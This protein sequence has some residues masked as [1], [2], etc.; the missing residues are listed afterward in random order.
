MFFTGTPSKESR[1]EL[2]HLKEIRY[3]HRPGGGLSEVIEHMRK[4]KLKNFD[5]LDNSHKE[6]WAA[7]CFALGLQQI[8]NLDFWIGKPLQDPPDMVVMTIGKEGKFNAREVEV[9][10]MPTADKALIDYIMEKDKKVYPDKYILVCFVEAPGPQNLIDLFQE[11]PSRLKRLKNIVLVFHGM[12]IPTP[13]FSV[14]SLDDDT[15]INSISVVQVSP[16]FSPVQIHLLNSLKTWHEDGGKLAYVK[17]MQIYWGL[18]EGDAY[19]KIL[20]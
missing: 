19:P 1:L 8:E 5:Y 18:R 14:D 10:R 16:V 11:L 17:D 4:N 20:A 9:V 13:D 12:M 15:R 3:W 7:S 6:L 2:T